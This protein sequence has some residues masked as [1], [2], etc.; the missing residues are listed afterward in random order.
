LVKRGQFREDLFFRVSGVTIRLPPLRA[1]TEDIPDL[2]KHV[3]QRLGFTKLMDEL[4]MQRLEAYP[5]PGNVRQLL[6]VIQA[7]AETCESDI[8]TTDDLSP[9]LDDGS[10]ETTGEFPTWKEVLE[11][12]EREH[13][14]RALA[15]TGGNCEEAI[16]KLKMSKATFYERKKRYNL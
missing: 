14:L 7:V 9:F 11:K 3:L 12:A 2:V 8:V 4:A 10:S 1:R 13:I 15:L 6:K 16:R 5:W